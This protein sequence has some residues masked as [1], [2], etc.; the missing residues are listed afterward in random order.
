[1]GEVSEKED[2]CGPNVKTEKEGSVFGIFRI[3]GK[4]VVKHREIL[5]AG[6][7]MHVPPPAGVRPPFFIKIF[8]FTYFVYAQNST[9]GAERPTSRSWLSLHQWAPVI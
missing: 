2:P 7:K 8:I 9:Y 3:Q 5:S 4:D 1:M 6:I